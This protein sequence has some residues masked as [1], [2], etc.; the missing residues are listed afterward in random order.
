MANI[1]KTN[2]SSQAVALMYN[3]DELA[4]VRFTF[5]NNEKVP[6]NK[7]VLAALSPVFH[8]MFFGDL[9]EKDEVEITDANADGFR[10]FLQVFYLPE[11]TVTMDNIQT[12]I[13]LADKYDVLEYV[14]AS[15]KFLETKLTVN[16]MCWGLQLA[17]QLKSDA[18]I[19]FCKS[20]CKKSPKEIFATEA[21]KQCE[22]ETLENILTLELSCN[23]MDV[24]NACILWAK[25][26]CKENGLNE[27]TGENI[28]SQ[29]GDCF[30]LI[31]F[32]TMIIEEINSITTNYPGLFTL[33][34]FE[35]AIYAS[36]IHSYN[37]KIF[38][39]IPRNFV[40]EFKRLLNSCRGQEY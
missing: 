23:E 22:I 14:K 33:E 3:N 32:G 15:A 27:N 35:D 9:K 13:Q 26:A 36:T 24:F 30:K 31:R 37:P 17:L 2:A 20:E 29:L 19:E 40:W 39:R 21:F 6:A 4:D 34:E 7:A 8:S 12:V 18:L 10:V 25:N 1:L 11:V 16:N 38:S 28:R 5:N